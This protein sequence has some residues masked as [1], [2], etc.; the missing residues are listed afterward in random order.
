MRSKLSLCLGAAAVLFVGCSQ[1]QTTTSAPTPDAQAART[2]VANTPRTDETQSGLGDQAERLRN[3][4]E[5]FNAVMGVPDQSIPQ[6][7]LDRAECVVVVPN[8][9]KAAFVIGGKYGVGFFSCRARANDTG[10]SAPGTVRL[11]GG[12]F[13]FQIGAEETDLILLVMN[14]QGRDRLLRS[15]FQIGG[16]ASVAAGPVGRSATASTDAMMTAQ[17]LSWS[18]SRGV[19]AGAALQGTT[20]RPDPDENRQL[21][22]Q[23]YTNEQII[24]GGV[25][26][27]VPDLARQFSQMLTKYSPRELN[28]NAPVQPK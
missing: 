25:Q 6:E 9:K 3:A 26:L 19:F 16:E 12:S 17:I 21:Y 13:G 23:A 14:E 2:A 27:Q 18:R 7:L 28:Q 24:N 15:Q 5:A 8:M 10:W 22:G 1:R 4:I 20:V 11:E